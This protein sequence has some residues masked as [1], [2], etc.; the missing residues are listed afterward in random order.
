MWNRQ[1]HIRETCS[2][3][4]RKLQIIPTNEGRSLR[5]RNLILCSTIPRGGLCNHRWQF[6]TTQPILHMR[7]RRKKSRAKFSS[8]EKGRAPSRQRVR[9]RGLQTSP[10]SIRLLRLCKFRLSKCNRPSR[11]RPTRLIQQTSISQRRLPRGE[12]QGRCPI[13]KHYRARRQRVQQRN[14]GKRA[15]T[16]SLLHRLRRQRRDGDRRIQCQGRHRITSGRTC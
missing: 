9:G 2:N 10:Q 6:I 15:T 13:I 11:D 4:C 3:V 8:P 12:H 14:Q 1:R 7:R 16:D 5:R